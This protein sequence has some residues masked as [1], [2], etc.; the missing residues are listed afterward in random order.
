MAAA[1]RVSI[2]GQIASS[3]TAENERLLLSLAVRL[4][5]SGAGGCC[6]M[7]LG[8][9][10]NTVPQAGDA[11]TVDLDAGS[12][13]QRVFT[14]TVDGVCVDAKGIALIAYDG[15]RCL[16]AL[17]V[18]A[19]YEDVAVDFVVKDLLSLGGASVGTVAPGFRLAAFRIKREPGVLYHLR[20]LASWCGADLYTDGAGRVHCTT[21]EQRGSEHC[22]Q[23]TDT[24]LQVNLQAMPPVH[25][26]AEICGEGAAASQGADKWYWLAKDLTGV[27]GKAAMDEHGTVSEGKTGTQTQ[28]LVLGAARSGEAAGHIAVAR[29]RAFAAHRLR[30]FVEVS[31]APGVMPG[32]RVTIESIPRGHALAVLLQGVPGLRVRGVHHRLSRH[33]GFVTRLEF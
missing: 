7:R 12:G 22:L 26:G 20:Q 23:F 33:V 9:L 5:M 25:D 31:G 11:V 10:D 15:L 28:R 1:Y 19:A 3:T 29:A 4:D 6:E 2:G 32:D 16:A 8:D 17:E 30:G 18:D 21:P 24:I 14:G 13:R 27:S